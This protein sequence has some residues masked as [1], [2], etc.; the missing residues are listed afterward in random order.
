MKSEE[1]KTFNFEVQNCIKVQVKAVD[2]EAARAELIETL[3]SY[4]E[5]MVADATVSEGELDG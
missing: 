3:P 2:R 1:L 4:A 5:E